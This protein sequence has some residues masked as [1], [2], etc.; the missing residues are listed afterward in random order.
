MC[1]KSELCQNSKTSCLK[2]KL[3]TNNEL[4]S[5]VVKLSQN[6]MKISLCD[7]NNQDCQQT[8]VNTENTDTHV[9]RETEREKK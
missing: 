3:L 4:D 5:K 9:Q 7:E 2:F 6:H 1:E 8:S